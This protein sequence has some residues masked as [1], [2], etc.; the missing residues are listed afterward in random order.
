MYTPS[1]EGL[2]CSCVTLTCALPARNAS[3]QTSKEIATMKIESSYV[4]G[5]SCPALLLQQRAALFVKD[6]RQRNWWHESNGL[7][8]S[9]PTASA[10]HSRHSLRLAK[11]TRPLLDTRVQFLPSPV[12][13]NYCLLLGCAATLSFAVA[14]AAQSTPA[15]KP[16]ITAIRSKRHLR[17]SHLRTWKRKP[18]KRLQPRPRNRRSRLIRCTSMG[19]TSR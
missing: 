11:L 6:L 10:V 4:A 5:S 19:L 18:R 1:R 12:M 13:P 2:L 7:S 17:P 14:I 16:A 3:A 8:F 9:F 15:I